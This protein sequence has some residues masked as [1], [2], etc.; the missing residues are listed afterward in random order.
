MITKI[1]NEEATIQIDIGNK[2]YELTYFDFMHR[3]VISDI[4]LYN[5]NEITQILN[6]DNECLVISSNMFVF[7]DFLIYNAEQ[8]DKPLLCSYTDEIPNIGYESINI[9]VEYASILLYDPNETILKY[10]ENGTIIKNKELIN[11]INDLSEKEKE[12]LI[13]VFK[14]YNSLWHY[15][16]YKNNDLYRKY[17]LI[18]EPEK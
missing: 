10:D 3:F 15:V 7:E 13:L 5:F 18:F 17:E 12:K 8:L 14:Q 2:T 11:I 9:C 16:S 1:I 4:T 6:K